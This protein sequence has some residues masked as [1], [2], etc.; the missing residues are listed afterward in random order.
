MNTLTKTAEIELPKI[1][2]AKW[3]AGV[4]GVYVDAKYRD[5][6]ETVAEV[7]CKERMMRDRQ[8]GQEA[9]QIDI[10]AAAHT[11]TERKAIARLIA[12]APNLLT[13]THDLLQLIER[14][15]PQFADTVVC[16]AARAAIAK[17]IEGES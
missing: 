6:N 12:A 16:D 17:A 4:R 7:G 5:G 14:E 1:A 9:Q 2:Q 13:A 10:D 15:L 3:T 8:E 11:T